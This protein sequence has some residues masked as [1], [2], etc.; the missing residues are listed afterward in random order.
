MDGQIVA[1]RE[2][3]SVDNDVLD[4]EGGIPELYWEADTVD[5][6]VVAA[7]QHILK[8]EQEVGS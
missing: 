6:L 8:K 4:L 3:R 2:D 7:G 1:P 5:E